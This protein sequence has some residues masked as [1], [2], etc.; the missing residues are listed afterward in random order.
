MCLG[1]GIRKGKPIGGRAIA[2]VLANLI[3]I[4]HRAGVE[5]STGDWSARLVEVASD[6]S[7]HPIEMEIDNV[8]FVGLDSIRSISNSILANLDSDDSGGCCYGGNHSQDGE[9]GDCATHGR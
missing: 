8:S 5:S 6:N 1:F 4:W 3:T 7:V 2:S 9:V